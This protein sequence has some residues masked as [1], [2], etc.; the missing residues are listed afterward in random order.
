MSGYETIVIKIGS[1]TL[2]LENKLDVKN[3]ERIVEEISSLKKRIIIVTSGAIVTGSQKLGFTTKPKTIPQKQAAAAIGQS[4]LMRQYEKAFEKYGITTAQVL[5]TRDAIEN[6]ERYLNVRNTMTTLLNEGVIPIVNENDTVAI[7]EIKVG[8]NDNL[9]ALVA[10]LIG[11]DLLIMLTDV[12]G[13]Y[14]ETPE[15][16]SYKVDEIS[17]ITEEIKQAAGHS[18][19]QLG[20]GGMATKLEAIKICMDAGV[21]VVIAYGR[22][23]NVLSKIVSGDKEGTLFKTKI[24]KLESRKRWLAHG[25]KVEGVIVVDDGAVLA[26]K[27]RGTSLLPVG[28]KEVNGC[29]G[30]GALI[31]VVG[32]KKEEIARGLVTLSSEELKKVLGKK[33]EREVIHRDNLVLL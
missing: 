29:F 27:I 3:L 14:M 9:A 26:L 8:D 2:T 1:S 21:Y 15:G 24:S 30:A 7:D 31:S 13:F 18:S 32:E 20:T 23:E 19:T 33:G 10:S 4:V 6:R 5:L 25:L 28:I 12:D 17:E 16:V 11:A 22:E